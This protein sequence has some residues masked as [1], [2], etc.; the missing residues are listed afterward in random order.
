MVTGGSG[1]VGHALRRLRPDWTYLSSR[2]YNLTEQAEVR[3]L[4]AEL[5]PSGVIH[6]AARVGG[7]KANLS[8]P[9]EFYYDNV[10]MNTFVLHEAYKVGVQKLLACLSTCAFPDVVDAYP[11][12]EDVLHQGPPAASNLTYGYSKRMVEVQIR[13]YRQQYGVH[14]TSVSPSNIY[15]PHDNFDPEQSH[16]VPALIR[17]LLHARETGAPSVEMWGTGR[18]LRQQLYVD[19]LAH[20]IVELFDRYDDAETVLVANPENL[21][22]HEIAETVA[23]VV[24][25]EGELRFNGQMDGQ[26]R[27][28]ADPALLLSLLPG[29]PFTPFAEGVARTLEWY[30]QYQESAPSVAAG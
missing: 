17:K 18:P 24:G 12:R 20:I 9:A 22:V 5:R 25:Y 28:D 30:Q 6:L 4:F 16:L 11:F 2:D 23:Q 29:F 1:L 13:A 21:S 19:D 26:F 10:S 27:K 8:S 3:R 15:G 7:I 14:F